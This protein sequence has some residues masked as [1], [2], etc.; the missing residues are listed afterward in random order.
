M[1]LRGDFDTALKRLLILS[2][3]IPE[4]DQLALAYGLAAMRVAALPGQESSG[5]RPAV[6]EVGRLGARARRQPAAR[7][8]AEFREVVTRFPATPGAQYAYG[9]FLAAHAY[10]REACEAFRAELR[11]SPRDV[12]SRLQLA[13]LESQQFNNHA[14]AARLA[15]EAVQL[16]PELY[17]SHF[18]LGRILLQT[19][20][21][22]AA[23][24]ELEAASKLAP[25]SLMVHHMLLTA[26]N[27]THRKDD[28]ARVEALL[29]E[30][31]Q[32]EAEWKGRA[33]DAEPL[34]GFPAPPPGP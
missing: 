18:V 27:K 12:M 11:N 7:T 33:S 22:E 25:D 32:F 26:Y 30:L 15:E 17:V 19:G 24:S 29:K 4:N 3:Q 16:A 21:A 31:Q 13:T 2:R 6:M 8:K 5:I 10:F 14:A 28:A 9:N 23:V 34:A 1:I 20:R